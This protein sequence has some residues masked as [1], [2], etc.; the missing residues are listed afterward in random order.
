[1][2][3]FR[4]CVAAGLLLSTVAF[5]ADVDVDAILAK[6]VAIDDFNDEFGDTP[7]QTSVGAAYGMVSFKGSAFKG[8]GYWY[9]YCDASGSTVTTIADEP[10]SNTD[11]ASL[12][13]VEDEDGEEAGGMFA[14]KLTTSESE[15]EYPYSVVACN[16]AGDDTKKGKVAL[17]FSKMTELSFRAKGE[18][19][20][21]I[22]LKTSDFDGEDWGHYGY[23]VTLTSSWKTY[24]V[25]ASKLVPEE[26]HAM[27]TKKKTFVD[28]AA[29]TYVME[30]KVK[31]GD[32]ATVYIDD[33]KAVGMTYA[34]FNWDISDV[35]IPSFNNN[36]VASKNLSVK[37]TNVSFSLAQSQNLT[38]TLNDIMGNKISTLFAGKAAS[39]S[40]NVG[41]MRIPN[42]R[43][44]VVLSGQNTKL[45]QPIAIMK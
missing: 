35:V 42:G 11:D 6:D 36:K 2:S 30:L 14:F 16:L 28:G 23:D 20:F 21:R 22:L 12:F 5:G 37:G 10:V 13:W 38:L 25:A 1:M 41:N 7:N 8:G 34:D 27:A 44:L 43:Y 31:N 15:E 39:K 17:D 26:G 4:S 3:I 24:T 45:V 9:S 18:G 32:D 40:I 19:S 33:I 29:E